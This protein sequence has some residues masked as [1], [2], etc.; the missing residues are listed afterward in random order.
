MENTVTETKWQW[1]RDKQ[2]RRNTLAQDNWFVG[3]VHSVVSKSKAEG[4]SVT[5]CL[6]VIEADISQESEHQSSSQTEFLTLSR[7]DKRLVVRKILHTKYK[8]KKYKLVEATSAY[9]TG[10]KSK[11][12]NYVVADDA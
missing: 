6:R 8:Q 12:L 3:I 4:A 11:T 5:L 1:D 10:K 7:T 2:E 9:R